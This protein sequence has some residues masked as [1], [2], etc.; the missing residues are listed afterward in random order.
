MRAV[1]LYDLFVGFL[2]VSL[3]AFGGGLPWARHQVVVRKRWLDEQEF[4]DILSLCQFMPGPNI[5]S[6]TVCVGARLR[7]I[8][9][10]FASLAGFIVIPWVIGFALGAWYLHYAHI[11]VLQNIL[12]GV[13]A[14][15]AGMIM[16]VGVRL[17]SPHRRRPAALLFA[18]L[19][20]AALAF[21]RLPLLVVVAVLAPLSIGAA[22]L[23]RRHAR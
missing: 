3:C 14:A 17:F 11:A 5:A 16:A 9:G 1:G 13:S 8:P 6:V 19:S 4:A 12:H 10:A 20:F 18:V 2:Q 7:G 15:A 23:E 22:Y 21:G